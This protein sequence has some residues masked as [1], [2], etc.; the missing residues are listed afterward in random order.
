MPT[1][2]AGSS[3]PWVDAIARSFEPYSFREFHRAPLPARIARNGHLGESD[4]RG[5]PSLAFRSSGEAFTWV[6]SDEG[7]RIVAGDAGADTVVELSGATVSESIRAVRRASGGVRAGRA[8]LSNGDL[9]GWKRWEPAIQS[10]CSG[11]AIYGTE[12]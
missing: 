2:V 1:D 7:V 3:L 10:L 6:A 12:V 11:R 5:V 9:S 4:R 8:K